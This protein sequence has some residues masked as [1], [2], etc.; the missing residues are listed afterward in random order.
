MFRSFVTGSAVLMAAGTM[1]VAS[2]AQAGTAAVTTAA[3][4]TAAV[5]TAVSV[6]GTAQ[7]GAAA[8]Q[9][10]RTKIS[11][12]RCK[13]TCQVKAKV[14]NISRRNAYKATF[15]VTLSING[16]K[17]GTCSRYIGNIPAKRVRYVSCT[18]RSARL[19]NM[20]DSWESGELSRWNTYAKTN[21]SYTYYR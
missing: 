11:F 21:V 5:T 7:A 10:L 6:A 8:T 12:G 9:L 18:V 17:A 4:T 15:Y 3:V 13:D 16:R 20:W 1:F 19:A 14:T 2:P